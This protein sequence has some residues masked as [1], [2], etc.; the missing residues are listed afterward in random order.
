MSISKP[1]VKSCFYYDDLLNIPLEESIKLIK[2][3]TMGQLSGMIGKYNGTY[4]SKILKDLYQESLINL[5]KKNHVSVAKKD[6]MK[7]IDDHGTIN[8]VPID[9]SLFNVSCGAFVKPENIFESSVAPPLKYLKLGPQ[10]N[11]TL[12]EYH[13]QF[14]SLPVF[15]KPPSESVELLPE[16]MQ[17]LLPYSY[18]RHPFLG[19]SL[20]MYGEIDMSSEFGDENKMSVK[21]EA[22]PLID[23]N[24]TFN[25]D[26]ELMII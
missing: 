15:V 7:E 5:I 4:P 6:F 10:T 8:G 19:T 25:V 11:E 13:E 22:K 21:L 2:S 20:S 9:K 1:I 18:S 26:E 24:I 12:Q 3:Y 16:H 14:K 17:L 23:A